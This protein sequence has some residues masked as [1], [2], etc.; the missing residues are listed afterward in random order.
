M[1]GKAI[2][3]LPLFCVWGGLLADLV[4]I[5]CAIYLFAKVSFMNREQLYVFMRV[6]RVRWLY[7]QIAKIICVAFVY[8][9]SLFVLPIGIMLP[10][11]ELQADW[12]RLLY[13]LATTNAGKSVNLSYDISYQIIVKYSPQC[14]FLEAFLIIWG[15][16]IFIGLL[17]FWLSL[18]FSRMTAIVTANFF[19]CTLIFIENA[20]K[21]EQQILVQLVP[22]EWIKITKMGLTNYEGVQSLEFRQ[23][24]FRL[25]IINILLMGLIILRKYKVEY[26]WYG[27]K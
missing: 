13:T 11:V 15:I 9:L 22:T 18:Y 3:V 8:V 4:V 17:M 7:L 5:F 12:G 2:L 6:G 1:S 23:I 10:H 14:L 19:A 24:I 26:D 27:D 25:T 16:I 21:A 20:R